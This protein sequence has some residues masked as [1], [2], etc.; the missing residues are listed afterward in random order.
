MRKILSAFAGCAALLVSIAASADKHDHEDEGETVH[1]QLIG[2]QEVPSIASPGTAVFKARIADD[3]LS[4]DW[5]LTYSGLPGITQSHIHVAQKGVSGGIVVWFCANNPP[6][7]NAPAGTQTCPTG[8]GTVR[9]TATAKDVVPNAATTTAQSIAVGELAKV[10]DAIRS[11][12]AY[13]NIHT[14]AHGPG[15]IRGQISHGKPK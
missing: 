10:L 11:G 15:E 9:G 5:E 7:T 12:V 2:W 4:F 8:A 1:A 6:I 3:D 14:V 13:A